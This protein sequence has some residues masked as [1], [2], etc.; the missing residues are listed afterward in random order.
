MYGAGV[1]GLSDL[2]S[3]Q[4][5]SQFLQDLFGITQ[6]AGNQQV[7]GTGATGILSGITGIGSGISGISKGV[8][9]LASLFGGG[10]NLGTPGDLTG[11]DAAYGELANF[12]TDEELAKMLDTGDIAY[13]PDTGQY[14]AMRH[15]TGLDNLPT[16]LNLTGGGWPMGWTP[17]MTT[18][19]PIGEGAGAWDVSPEVYEQMTG[20]SASSGLLNTI[21]DVAPWAGAAY[22]AYELFAGETPEEK[23]GGAGALTAGVASILG[24]NPLIGAVF[25]PIAFGDQISSWLRGPPTEVAGKSYTD[26]DNVPGGWWGWLKAHPLESYEAYD[27]R[28]YFP[29]LEQLTGLTKEQWAADRGL[30]LNYE[31]ENVQQ[32]IPNAYRD[33]ELDGQIVTPEFAED[34]KARVKAAEKAGTQ[35]PVLQ[36]DPAILDARFGPDSD[37]WGW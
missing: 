2:A 14:E 20:G 3:Q 31:L 33:P 29:E 13:N 10:G 15:A 28:I 26:F 24:S 32:V 9:G 37:S 16:D 22:G 19:L 35:P 36:T 5:Q 17:G 25:A 27:Q 1:S 4:A 23:A 8:G 7:G 21:K 34:Y 11:T 18:G 12:Y 30:N 6:G